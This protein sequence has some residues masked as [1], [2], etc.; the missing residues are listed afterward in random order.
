VTAKTSPQDALDLFRSKPEDFDLIVT[1]Y[2]MPQMAGTDLARESMKIRQDIPI[3]LCTGFSKR[4]TEEA[5]REM[6]IRG[7]AM[8][9][10][11]IKRMAELIREVLDTEK[12]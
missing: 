6:G 5:V 4:V 9:P 12:Q 11:N 10:L 2:T 8:K 3:I 7:F 1:D